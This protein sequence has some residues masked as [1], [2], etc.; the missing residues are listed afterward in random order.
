MAKKKWTRVVIGL[1][2]LVAVGNAWY[3]R[4]ASKQACKVL[5]MCIPMPIDSLDPAVSNRY[6]SAQMIHKVYDSLLEYHYL[7]RPFEL[8]PNLVEGMPEISEDERIYTFKLK[9][10]VF[11]HDDPCFPNGKG[12]ELTSEDVVYTFKRLAD[13]A[14]RSPFYCHFSDLIEGF[15]LLHEH[16]KEKADDYNFDIDG[17]KSIDRYTVQFTLTKP[18]PLFLNYITMPCGGIVSKDAVS[19]YQDEFV[20]H[21][22]GTGPFVLKN[23]N[24]QDNRLVFLKNNNFRAKAYPSDASLEYQH[25]LGSAG[26]QLPLLDKVIVSIVAEDSTSWLLFKNRA[27]DLIHL[28]PECLGEVFDQD[29]NLSNQSKKDNIQLNSIVNTVSYYIGLNCEVPPLNNKKLRQAMSLAFDR[30]RFNALFFKELGSMQH[31]F[32]PKDFLGYDKTY[33]N[34]YHYDLEKAKRY[35]SELG[36]PNGEGLQPISLMTSTLPPMKMQAEFF[37]QCMKEIG[38][39][40]EIQPLLYPELLRRINER[41]YMLVALTWTPDF[42][43]SASG[44]LSIIRDPNLG[45]GIYINDSAFNREYDQSILVK[46]EVERG[47]LYRALDLWATE[48]VPAIFIPTIPYYVLTYPHVKNY[49]IDQANCGDQVMYLDIDKS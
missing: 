48:Q 46:N 47:K 30:E 36:Y 4:F 14:V 9:S 2:C 39:D 5:R 6:H 37:A 27:I 25:L 1:V 44:M 21:P 24:P 42:P 19:Y 12:K 35:L 7:K 41:R 3:A 34:P 32:I 20:N 8:R 28:S 15:S 45:G 13:P 22:I 33:E 43:D 11:F 26:K 49:V 18:F 38:I 40:V 23:Y 29:L 31:S 16:F 10:G 17:L